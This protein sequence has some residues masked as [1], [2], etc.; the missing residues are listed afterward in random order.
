MEIWR[1]NADGSQPVQITNDEYQNWF[2]HPS[3]DD[4]QIVFLSYLPDVAPGDHPYYK[5]VMLRIMDTVTFR[6]RVIAH[7]YG[8]QGTI[9]VPSWSPDGKK[10]AFVSNTLVDLSE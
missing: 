2:P 5:H 10:V 7:L 4:S 3:P 9:N 8:G 6:P 1:M